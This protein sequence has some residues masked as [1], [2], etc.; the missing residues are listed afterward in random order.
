MDT[1][2]VGLKFTNGSMIAIDTITAEEAVTDNVYQRPEPGWLIYDK[3]L[4][5]A[6]FVLGENVGMYV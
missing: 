2:F 6:Q 1:A 5:Y 4:K 3:T